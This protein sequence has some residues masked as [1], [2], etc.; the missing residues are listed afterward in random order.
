MNNV[1]NFSKDFLKSHEKINAISN[2]TPSPL[3]YQ[4]DTSD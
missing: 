1:Y 3:K 2:S 4:T